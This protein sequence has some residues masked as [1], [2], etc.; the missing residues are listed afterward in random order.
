VSPWDI[1]PV[2]F[3]LAP[4]VALFFL[5]FASRQKEFRKGEKLYELIRAGSLHSVQ[6]FLKARPFTDTR[7]QILPRALEVAAESGQVEILEFLLT[8]GS[9]PLT[10]EQRLDSFAHRQARRGGWR[11]FVFRAESGL[12]KAPFE[13]STH[14]SEARRRK[15]LKRARGG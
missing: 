15:L 3:G 14:L 2:V 7:N 5:Y 4:F 1:F 6:E 9:A 10:F 13:P 12:H 11:A 8:D